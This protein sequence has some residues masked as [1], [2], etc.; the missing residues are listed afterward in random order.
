MLSLDGVHMAYGPR[1][2]LSAVSLIVPD[3]VFTPVVT[4]GLAANEF[5]QF[6]LA[7]FGL[8]SALYNARV[9]V[10]VVAGTGKVTAYGSAIDLITQDPTYV[11]AQ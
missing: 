9:A 4:I 10:K 3:A 7:D 8:G 11:P 2:V 1:T 6:S 5:R